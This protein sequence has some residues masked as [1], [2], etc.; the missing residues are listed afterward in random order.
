MDIIITESITAETAHR[1]LQ[2]ML[3]KRD[4]EEEP[5]D[6][7]VYI[8]SR[9]GE[10]EPG[11]AIYEML[12]C[13]GRKIIT[14]GIGEVYSCAVAL[15]LAGDERYATSRTK[16]MIHEVRH[17]HGDESS[18]TTKE[19]EK[20]LKEL[21]DDTAKYFK[22]ISENSKLTP[23]RIKKYLQKAKDGDWHFDVNQAKKFGFV[24]KVGMPF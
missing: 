4:K 13:S 15:F 8:S 23:A 21:Q 24:T 22:L 9:G 2:E 14:C 11:Y 3:L 12:K 16:F 20:Y 17:I 7:I 6:I 1:V 19:Y 18:L 10:L 5:K